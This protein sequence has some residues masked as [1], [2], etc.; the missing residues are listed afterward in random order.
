MASGDKDVDVK[1]VV[2]SDEQFDGSSNKNQIP[3]AGDQSSNFPQE[4]FFKQN[5][6]MGEAGLSIGDE[7]LQQAGSQ[8]TG[9]SNSSINSETLNQPHETDSQSAQELSS[10]SVSKSSNSSSKSGSSKNNSTDSSSVL[11]SE[12]QN[13]DQDNISADS[14]INQTTNFV[15]GE[16]SVNL[17]SSNS[18]GAESNENSN[19]DSAASSPV[20]NVE[21][22]VGDEDTAISLDISAALTDNDGSESLFIEIKDIPEGAILSDGVNS[23]SASASETSVNISEWNTNTLTIIPASNSDSD[24]DLTISATSTEESNNDTATA[25]ASLNVV[26]NS[27]NDAPEGISLDGTNVAENSDGAVIGTV[28]TSDADV[29]DSHSYSV[30]DDRFEVVNDGDGN[31]QLKLKDGQSFNYEKDSS[32]DVTVVST[33]E[34][35]LSV[36]QEFTINIDDVNDFNHIIGTDNNDLLRGTAGDDK[37]EALD[38]NDRVYAGDGH[39]AV[40]GGA[41][42]D[43][44]SG[45]GGNDEVYGGAGNDY[46]Y[47]GDGENVLDG[48][49]GAD[50]IYAHQGGTDEIHGGEGNDYIYIDGNDSV[51]GGDGTDR[52]YTYGEDDISLNMGDANVEKCL[53]TNRC[54]S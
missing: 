3:D 11:F 35:G 5:I 45:Q 27:V 21:Q 33:D 26:I 42:N 32:V 48:G 37:I 20:L 22:A 9:N 24:F 39:D 12:A 40:Y 54:R 18:P 41:G 49:D 28:S 23:F 4:E 51:D 6:Q 30:S 52:V 31:M 15:S 43:V 34:G 50:R 14:N 7:A 8:D 16:E 17:G 29:N 53:C 19:V 2:L 25:T 38:G 44:L 47:G 10:D 1:K 13:T 36:S 46:I